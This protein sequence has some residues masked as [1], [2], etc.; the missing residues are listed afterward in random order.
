MKKL[1]LPT[2]AHPAKPPDETANGQSSETDPRC[3]ETIVLGIVSLSVMW[4]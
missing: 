1:V 3:S 2:T 4:K